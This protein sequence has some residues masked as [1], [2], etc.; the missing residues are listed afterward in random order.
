MDLLRIGNCSGFWGDRLSAA[1]EMVRDGP[2]DVLT[3]DY[4]AELS[5]AILHRARAKD[6]RAGYVPTFVKQLESVLGE[7]LQRGIKI[8]SNAGGL[9]PRGLAQEIEA[10]AARLGLRPKVAWVDGDD[11]T[12]RIPALAQAGERLV[13]LDHGV[14]LADDKRPVVTANAYLGGWGIREALARGADVVVT[15]R[16]TDAALVV[17]PAA[18]RFGWRRDDWDRL[19]GA[20]AAGHVLECSAQATGGNYAFF[21][22]VPSFARLGFPLAELAADGSFVVTKHPGTGG[23]VSVGTVTAQL[24][25]E[26]QGPAYVNPDVVAHFDTLTLAQV[27]PDRVR[28]SGARGTP[29]P[30]T[31]KA[32]INC[33]GGY[34]NSMTLLLGG[35]DLPRKAAIVEEQLFDALGG[36]AQFSHVDVRLERM[37]EAEPRTNEEAVAHLKVT[38]MSPDE[39]RVGRRFANAAVELA[40]SSVPGFSARTPPGDATPYLVFWP[41]LLDRRHIEERVHIDGGSEV[42]PP[43]PTAPLATAPA[44]PEGQPPTVPGP[45]TRVR[46]GQLFGARSGD[47]G[48]NAN[49]GLWAR[50]DRSYAFLRDH[51][52]SDRLKQLCPDFAPFRVTRDALPNLRAVHFVI[53]GLLGEGVAASA[54]IDPQAK[55]LAEYVRAV[56]VDV[57][58]QLLT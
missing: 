23:L 42:V 32:S 47:K 29:P 56:F 37:D 22:E 31:L 17:G 28:V 15:G 19:A 20:V 44:A 40:L 5:M 14:P 46:L 51:L 12:A 21:E 8:V 18:W 10:L 7:C 41:A 2:L 3:G 49:L 9:N 30:P 57:P 43:P 39:K 55:T 16:V 6:S 27:G 34:R 24:L 11:F 35:T 4:L 50:D 54:R 33:V 53:H 25:Y 38:V 13:H 36:R 58:A 48:G 52:T 26:I 45:T 1:E